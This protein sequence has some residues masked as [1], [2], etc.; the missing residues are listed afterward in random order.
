MIAGQI[1]AMAGNFI[2]GADAASALPKLRDLWDEGVAFSVDLLGEAC[3]SDAEARAYQQRYLDLIGSLPD[4]VAHWP[5]NARGWIATIWGPVPRANVSIK[6][7]SLCGPHRSDR[8]PG[9]ARARWA[10]PAADPRAA[11]AA[12]A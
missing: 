3:V 6:I 10:S 9:R 5:A 12:A 7:S 8:F 11:A 4:E 1:R 2:A